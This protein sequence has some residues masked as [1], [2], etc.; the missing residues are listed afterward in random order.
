[1]SLIKDLHENGLPHNPIPK[2][3]V[4]SIAGWGTFYFI[5]KHITKQ[6]PEWTI[7]MVTAVHATIV[8]ILAVLDWSYFQVWDIKKLGQIKFL[9]TTRYSK[10]CRNLFNRNLF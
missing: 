9:N 1:M 7:R 8:T 6:E 10:F 2:M 4:T 3:V 5:L